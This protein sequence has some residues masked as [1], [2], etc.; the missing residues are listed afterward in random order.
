MFLGGARV[1]DTWNLGSRWHR[2]DPHLHAPGT[3]RNNQFGDDWDGYF[4]RI[5]EASPAPVALGITDYF[6]LRCYKEFVRRRP[7]GALPTVALVFPNIELRLTIET[8][9]RQGI[10]LHLLVSPD[11]PDHVGRIEEKL[12]GLRYKY[13]DDWYTCTDD[14]LKRLG[15]AHKNAPDLKDELALADG[16]NQFKIE[17][18]KLRELYETDPWIRSNVLVAV[19]AGNDGLAGLT[20]DASFHAQREEL[21]RFAH[22]VFSGNPADRSYWL[23]QHP[24]FE[25]N[26]Q[27]PKPCLHGSDC[28][29]L[30]TVLQPEIERRCWIRAEPTFNG[31]RQTLAEPDRRVYVGPEPPDGPSAGD[32]IRHVRFRSAG[33]LQNEEIELNPGLVTV[34]GSRGSGKTALADLI[35]LAAEADEEEPGDA[36]FLKKA[37]PLLNGLEVEIEWADGTSQ[38]TEYPRSSFGTKQPRVRYLSQKFVESLCAPDGGGDALDEEIEHVVFSAIPEEDRFQCSDFAELRRLLLDDAHAQQASE[39]AIIRE[40]TNAVATETKLQQS[41]PALDGK[42]KE[43]DRNRKALDDELKKLP[44]KANEANAKAHDTASKKLVALKEAIAAEQR[45]EKTLQDLTAEVRRYAREVETGWQRLQERYGSAL[46]TAQ[47]EELR[48]TLPGTAFSMM[49]G[50]EKATTA[51]SAELRRAGMPQ[52][53]GATGEVA[54]PQGLV[55][56][57]AECE[58]LSKLLGLDTANLKK[59][60]DLLAKIPVAKQKEET[61][62]KDLEHSKKAQE[63]RKE[64]QTSRLAAYEALFAAIASEEDALRKLYGPL[65]EQLQKDARLQRLSFTVQRHV[66]LDTW[67]RQGEQLF[68]LRKRPFGDASLEELATRELLPSWTNGSAAAVREAMASV[69]DNHVAHAM[70]TLAQGVTFLDLGEWLFATDHI[71]VHYGIEY[72]GQGLSTL[73]PGTRGVVLLTLYLALDQ[74]DRRPLVIDQP[75]ENLDP[76]SVY[77]DLRPFFRDASLRRQIVMVTHNAN[78]V[79]NTDSDQVIVASATR[80]AANELP[81]VTYA[82]GGLEDAKTRDE[83]CRILEG[84]REAFDKRRQR[85]E[86]PLHDR[87]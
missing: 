17:L 65:R 47:W 29:K 16:A 56:L 57:E 48:A 59:R 87:K 68:D 12:A 50:L 6:S 41:I 36:S 27:T 25:R 38:S 2:W 66:D 42:F 71:S 77:D 82:A 34:I 46:E 75:E 3:L 60:A 5:A 37:G 13:R 30:D 23:G 61:A 72:E 39:R 53:P 44:I 32:V 86:S 40:K 10:N 7:P 78:L 55:A 20:G 24:D 74:W 83:V 28:H 58:A 84:G 18:G 76:R 21:G 11:D 4:Q 51:K 85:Y 1:S 64:L 79:V 52:S 70:G 54:K 19:A 62:R 15:R 45:R 31:F 35:A 80:Q 67:V 9:D 63:R 22:I 33:W 49:A 73:S 43:A 81:L 8:K 69:L 14:G 26:G